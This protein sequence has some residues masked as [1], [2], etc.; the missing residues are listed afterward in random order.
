[1]KNISYMLL[2]LLG[3]FFFTSCNDYETYADL[4]DAERDAINRFIATRGIRVITQTQFELQG[5]T[6]DVS[7]NQYVYLDKSGVYMQIVRKG[8]GEPVEDGKVTNLLC[9]FQEYNI[10]TDSML[11][12]NDITLAQY[13]D[14][15]S[16]T[17]SGSNFTASFVSG[18]M[19]AYHGS[20]TV[21]AGWLVPL[22]YINVGRPQNEGDEIAKVKL[23]VPHSQGTSDASS[24]VYPCYY[25]ITYVRD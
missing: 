11:I 17:R 18:I 7:T 25:E 6:T 15:M 8:C 21:P 9:R 19:M 16:V 1:M 4:K 22:L 14:K 5:Q 2:M 23:I 24:T 20:S 10:K 13:V 12:R 3:V